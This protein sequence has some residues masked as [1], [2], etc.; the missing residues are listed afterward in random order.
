MYTPIP[1][2]RMQTTLDAIICKSQFEFSGIFHSLDWDFTAFV[3]LLCHKFAMCK[4]ILPFLSYVMEKNLFTK[5]TLRT[6]ISNL[7]L[8]KRSHI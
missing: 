7:K 8:K 5:Y 3:R 4:I 2:N 1:E 6:P